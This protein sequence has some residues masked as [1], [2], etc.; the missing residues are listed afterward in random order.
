[1]VNHKV[2]GLTRMNRKVA[3]NATMAPY[4]SYELNAQ[5]NQNIKKDL[6]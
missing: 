3:L 4:N 5:S 2:I 6:K 1:M